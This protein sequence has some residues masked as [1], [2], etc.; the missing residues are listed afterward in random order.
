MFNI[1]SYPEKDRIP[2]TVAI[3]VG[4]LLLAF[5][6]SA[7]AVVQVFVEYR[8]LTGWLERDGPVPV[9]EIEALRQDVGTRIIVRSIASAV[10]LLC[11]LCTLWLQ[12]RQLAM[13][14]TLHQVKL[15][16]HHILASLNQGVV[17]TDQRGVITSINSAATD[18]IGADVA[19]I[20]QPIAS[21]STPEAPLS[22]LCR[23][24]IERKGAVRDREL[25][26][27]RGGRER[28][29]VASALELKD[30]RGA[31]IGCVINLRDVTERML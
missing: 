23:P 19:C 20:G 24:V 22:D 15:L 3:V 8:M 31:T 12:Q 28:R 14:R 27:D 26:V 21:I 7:T 25:T 1:M 9:A 4:T 16:A 10:L 5:L 11:T 2:F 18:L 13:R 29:L 6:L 17:T 30:T